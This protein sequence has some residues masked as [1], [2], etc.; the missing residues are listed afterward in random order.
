MTNYSE[1]LFNFM[2]KMKM[3]QKN[4]SREEAEKEVVEEIKKAGLG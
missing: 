2:V 3:K 1:A 4:I